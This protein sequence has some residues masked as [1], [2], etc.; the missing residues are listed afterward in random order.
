[1]N[2]VSG[3]AYEESSGYS[4]LGLRVLSQIEKY[5]AGNVYSAEFRPLTAATAL[6][7]MLGIPFIHQVPSCASF[8]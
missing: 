6:I 2:I 4:C 7:R 8:Q 5:I 1:M 3:C